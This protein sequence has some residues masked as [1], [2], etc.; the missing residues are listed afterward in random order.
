MTVCGIG[1]YSEGKYKSSIK[2]KMTKE[3]SLWVSMLNRCYG[4][5]VHL[6]VPTYK[7]CEVSENFKNFQYF[8]EWCNNQLGFGT[9]GW[10]LDKDLLVRGNKVYSEETCVFIPRVINSSITE[11]TSSKSLGV[12]YDLITR[13]Y[14]VWVYKEDGS[15]SLIHI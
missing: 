9:K 1:I 12:T 2:R 3:Y 6:R 7:T 4:A 14:K 8:A 15:L 11:K 10:E 13:G 5:G